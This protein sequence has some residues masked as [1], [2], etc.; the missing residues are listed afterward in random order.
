MGS[1]VVK[2]DV[3]CQICSLSGGYE[4]L[5][6]HSGACSP[7]YVILLENPVQSRHSRL[8]NC[9]FS[10]CIALLCT[11]DDDTIEMLSDKAV[12]FSGFV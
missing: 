4:D 5:S 6:F 7:V 11:S 12:C 10:F 3:F 1:L 2:C 9:F 8:R